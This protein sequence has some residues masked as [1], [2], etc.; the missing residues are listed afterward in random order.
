MEICCLGLP[1]VEC[2]SHAYLSCLPCPPPQWIKSTTK[3]SL[4]RGTT[5]QLYGE[6]GG[7]PALHARCT[8]SAHT[9]RKSGAPLLLRRVFP[10]AAGRK[11]R[12]QRRRCCW[13]SLPEAGPHLPAGQDTVMLGQI[14][15][16]LEKAAATAKGVKKQLWSGALANL[17]GAGAA[18]TTVYTKV[19]AGLGGG[20]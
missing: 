5:W 12:V 15:P 9:S 14:P 1:R 16:D 19:G 17:T 4:A 10:T 11:P 6:L 13:V 3:D 18:S 2:R 8:H 20:V 7:P